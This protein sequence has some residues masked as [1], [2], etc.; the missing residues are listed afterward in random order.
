MLTTH[1]R[2]VRFVL[3]HGYSVDVAFEFEWSPG[4]QPLRQKFVDDLAHMVVGTMERARRQ[5]Q[6]THCR[7]LDVHEKVRFH[8]A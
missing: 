5:H 7:P 3:D 2:E 8:N 4:F 1:K 6:L